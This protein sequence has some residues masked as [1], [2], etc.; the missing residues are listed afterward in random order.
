ML[1]N[2]YMRKLPLPT[3]NIDITSHA[4]AITLSASRPQNEKLLD[5]ISPCLNSLHDWLESGK[6]KL[7][8]EK[9]IATLFTTWRKEAEFD[10]YL[11]I[12]NSSIPVKSKVKLLGVSFDSMLNLGEHVRSTKEKLSA[13][14][15]SKRL[16][17]ANGVA[18]ETLSVTYKAIGR[19]VLN[20]GAPLRIHNLQYKLQPP[21]NATKLCCSHNYWL[22]KNVRHQ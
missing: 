18:Q 8:T 22:C 17:V 6:L 7:S 3:E 20:Y 12:S 9:L 11:T 1:F 21:A 14:T 5:M 13:I 16:L 15:Y 19:S 10:P 2:A 4:D